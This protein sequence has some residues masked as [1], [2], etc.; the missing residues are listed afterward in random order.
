MRVFKTIK[1]EGLKELSNLMFASSKTRRL[2]MPLAL[3]K[4]KKRFGRAGDNLYELPKELE[5][6]Y[7]YVKALLQTACQRLDEKLISPDVLKTVF[8]SFIDNVFFKGHQ[9]KERVY[10]E[11][12]LE[13]PTLLVIA[14]GS[15]C[16][17]RCKGCYAGSDD[18][19][20]AKLDWDT[21]DRILTEK[22]ELWSS[23]FTVLTGGEPF[24][25]ADKG[26]TIYD[27]FLKHKNQYFMVYTNGTLLNKENVRKIAEAGNVA[28]AISVEGFKKETDWRRGEGVYDRILEAF[29]NLREA[30]NPFGISATPMRHN[31]E[32]LVSDEFIDFYF[33]KEKAFFGWLFQYMPIGREIDMDLMVTP[34]QRLYMYKRSRY[35][36]EKRG[37]AYVDFWNNGYLSNGCIAAFRK[38]GYAYINWD[39][40]VAP[41]AFVPYYT[42]NIYEIYKNG[43]DLNTARDCRFFNDVRNWQKNYGYMQPRDK[44]GNRL[45]PCPIRDHH[46][47]MLNILRKHNVKPLDPFAEEALKSDRYH[48]QLIEYNKKVAALLDPEW[49]SDFAAKNERPV[50]ENL[51]LV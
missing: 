37:L 32:L 36:V 29:S 33:G 45:M 40:N 48:E 11:K 4:L 20:A 18:R 26:K 2:L 5:A 49:Q 23:Y 9:M 15:R 1:K 7:Y 16:N 17:L 6:Q 30:G 10:A 38:G 50:F 42:V 34:E 35:I 13:Y 41:C 27:M 25:W 24:M 19:K 51:E 46:G 43:G 21:F 44:V 31:A 39:G 28:P 8:D 3:K 22:E 47:D 12:K 14:P